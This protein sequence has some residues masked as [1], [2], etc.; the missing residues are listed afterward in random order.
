MQL[1]SPDFLVA[2]LD[3]GCYLGWN[4]TTNR[5]DVIEAHKNGGIMTLR[6]YND[7]ILSGDRNGFI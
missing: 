1:V 7:F 4:L 2:G 3:N 5:P 6:K